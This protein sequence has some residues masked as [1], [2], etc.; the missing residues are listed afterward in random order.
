M[1]F[2]KNRSLMKYKKVYFCTL[3]HSMKIRIFTHRITL[4][5]LL[6]VGSCQLCYC[7]NSQQQ[8]SKT[9][10]KH[11]QT[12]DEFSFYAAGAYCSTGNEQPTSNIQSSVYHSFNHY[13]TS[14]E[15][16]VKSH[17]QRRISVFKIILDNYFGRR[18]TQGYYTF[19]Q[20]R[21]RC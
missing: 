20:G 9:T 19:A 10:S 2:I 1:S 13:T 8:T 6:L 14:R 11:E 12:I 15:T 3:F 5:L 17:F 7:L 16:F 4:L 21:L 18:L